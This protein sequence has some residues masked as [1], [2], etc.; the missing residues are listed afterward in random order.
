[1]TAH[2]D[3]HARLAERARA[4]AV[5]VAHV[6]ETGTSLLAF[7]SRG[8]KAVVL[9]VVKHPGDEWESGE[10]VA[11]FNGKGVVRIFEYASGALLLER[12]TPATPLVWSVREER[13]DEATDA[14]AGVIDRMR[15]TE[16]PARCMTVRQWGE[17]FDRYLMRGDRQI[18]RDLV[19]QA[20]AQYQRLC[21]SQPRVQLLHGDLHHYNVLWD[22]ARGW[23]AVDPK[24]V[25][26][27]IEYEVGAA[28]RN[29]IEMQDFVSSP[30]RLQN[31]VERFS[32][33]LGL[34]AERVL[35]WGFAQAVL[36]AIWEV[37]D[38][39]AVDAT[40]VGLRLAQAIGTLRDR[41][42]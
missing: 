28:L 23:I 31:G 35:D 2:P 7:G 13:D 40:H 8:H 19:H 9:K 34:D 21:A 36:S 33:R 39:R 18:P 20:L 1:M 11:A 42:T 27:E 16:P 38:G 17:A 22:S 25:S 4:W 26:G 30:Q 24:G 41:Q 3:P 12:L 6:L 32:S 29:P 14:L 37:E 10:I 5:S 15:G